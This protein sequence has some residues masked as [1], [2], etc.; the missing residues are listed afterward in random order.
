[1]DVRA[2]RHVFRGNIERALID[3]FAE[4]MCLQSPARLER[5]Y[6]GELASRLG[7][8]VHGGL[9]AKTIAAAQPARKTDESHLSFTAPNA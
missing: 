7:N 1:M 8:P 6:V 3:D 5:E 9:I 4:E 2:P